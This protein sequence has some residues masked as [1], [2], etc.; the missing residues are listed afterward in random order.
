MKIFCPCFKRPEKPFFQNRPFWLQ[1]KNC[2]KIVLQGN[3]AEGKTM[4]VSVSI[5]SDGLR[6][7]FLFCRKSAKCGGC[8]VRRA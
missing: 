5:P 3:R 2:G 6:L 4:V 7:V 1:N 8:I